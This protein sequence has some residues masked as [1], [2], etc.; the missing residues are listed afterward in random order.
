MWQFSFV[1]FIV[2]NWQK[3]FLVG[4]LLCELKK[5]SIS[6]KSFQLLT[7]EFL[8]IY[9]IDWLLLLNLLFISRL[10]WLV[11]IF[12]FKKKQEKRIKNTECVPKETKRFQK[13]ILLYLQLFFLRII[14]FTV[15]I[16]FQVRMLANGNGWQEWVKL[17]R[18]LSMFWWKW[19]RSHRTISSVS[20]TFEIWW[21]E[22][23]LTLQFRIQW[24]HSLQ[25]ILLYRI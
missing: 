4:F 22:S 21:T 6:F 10:L 13:K 1:S 25:N 9:F 19:C 23:N 7:V 8:F 12:H 3:S 16:L 5:L 18:A 2:W 17:I 24:L 14:A 11:G 20:S 15:N